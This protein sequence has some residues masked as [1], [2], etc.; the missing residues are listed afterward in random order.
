[1]E[2]IKVRSRGVESG[3]TLQYLEGLYAEYE[4][5]IT[6]ISKTVP[7]IRVDY[8]RF[9]DVEAMASAIEREYLQG[10]FLREVTWRPT[11]G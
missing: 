1:M 9:R 3:I 8:D 7:V 5:F 11:Q 4:R 10:A 6:D 2:R